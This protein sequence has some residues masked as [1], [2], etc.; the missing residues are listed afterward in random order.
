M[1]IGFLHHAGLRQGPL[2]VQI[3]TGHNRWTGK[4]PVR[5]EVRLLIT[6]DDGSRQATSLSVPLGPDWG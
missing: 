6:L 2:A 1:F 3:E 4:H 5:A